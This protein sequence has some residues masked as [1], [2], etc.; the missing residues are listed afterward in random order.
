[1]DYGFHRVLEPAGVIPQAAWK[2]D[3]RPELLRPTEVLLSVSM[4]NLDS[5]G[6]A[7]LRQAGG[8][9][10]ERVMAI[11][12]KRGKMHN[13]VSNSGGVLVGTV[14]EI[15]STAGSGFTARVGDIVIPLVSTSTL[16]LHLDKV[17]GIHGDQLSVEGTA[18]LFDGMAYVLAPDDIELPLAL[19]ILDISSIVPQVYR[20]VDS[21]HTALVI[22]AGKSGATAMAAI[23]NSA[24]GVRIIALDPDRERLDRLLTLG[25]ADVAIAADATLPQ[26]TLE[27]VMNA[28]SGAL[29]DVVLNCV[30]VADTE[31]TSI[32]CARRG[33]TVVFYSMATRFDKAALGTD[34]TD[35]DVHMVIG[36]GIAEN[37]ASLALALFRENAG[38]LAYFEDCMEAG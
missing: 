34:A 31:A 36:N 13:P 16:P 38:L 30:N 3:S 6:M 22:G 37:Q 35:N 19:S 7:Q 26:S 27:K 32:L 15:G 14:Q 25:L 11:V 17:T 29:C 9:I 12:R 1:M 18:V 28:T 33:G 24:A 10:G 5:T 21:G 8:E 2:L 4:L 20:H 23:R